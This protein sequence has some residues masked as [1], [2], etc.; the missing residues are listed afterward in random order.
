MAR[1]L[2]E[3]RVPVPTILQGDYSSD[4]E[5]LRITATLAIEH[6]MVQVWDDGTVRHPT[7]DHEVSWEFFRDHPLTAL[8]FLRTGEI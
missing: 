8:H 2:Q 3:L 4:P 6:Y 5:D 7:T 1:I